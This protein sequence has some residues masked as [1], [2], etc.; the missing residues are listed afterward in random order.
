[1]SSDFRLMCKYPVEEFQHQILSTQKFGIHFNKIIYLLFC[2]SIFHFLHFAKLHHFHRVFFFYFWWTS[3]NKAI[4]L[5]LRYRSVYEIVH[6][7]RGVTK[8]PF[9]RF[10]HTIDEVKVLIVALCYFHNV[11]LN[12]NNPQ[13][14]HHAIIMSYFQLRAPNIICNCNFYTNTYTYGA[15]NYDYYYVLLSFFANYVEFIHL[16]HV[17]SN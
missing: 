3:R 6:K 10:P 13:Q 5:L 12:E 4:L 14:F 17:K 1:M 15:K 7:S 16:Q 2:I 9:I 11:T 8:L